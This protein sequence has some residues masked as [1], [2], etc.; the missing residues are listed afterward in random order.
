MGTFSASDENLVLLI[1]ELMCVGFVGLPGYHHP[2][3]VRVRQL[4]WNTN[5]FYLPLQPEG[6]IGTGEV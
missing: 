4:L 2:Q 5:R 1:S 3:A 6:H